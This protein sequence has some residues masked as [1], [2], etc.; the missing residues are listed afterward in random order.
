MTHTVT[1][2]ILRL[3][4]AKESNLKRI[5]VRQQI[6]EDRVV[7][8]TQEFTKELAL[9]LLFKTLEGVNGVLYTDG[10]DP[11]NHVP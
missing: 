5:Q 7:F 1:Q 3:R 6:M 9:Y 4:D 10:D 11:Q 8:N 2:R